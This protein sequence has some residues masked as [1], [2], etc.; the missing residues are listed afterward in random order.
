MG[1]CAPLPVWRGQPGTGDGGRD[2]TFCSYL[3]HPPT[4]PAAACKK[5]QEKQRQPNWSTTANLSKAMRSGTASAAVWGLRFQAGSERRCDRQFGK[6]P[7]PSKI[8]TPVHFCCNCCAAS[9]F[10]VT[11]SLPPCPR[12]TSCLPAACSP[13]N[14]ELGLISFLQHSNRVLASVPQTAT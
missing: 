3:E 7:I 8:W 6:L 4:L 9:G 11:L 5:P 10:R 2:E 14:S 1:C 12:V 13:N